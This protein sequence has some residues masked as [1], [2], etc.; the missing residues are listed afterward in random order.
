MFDMIEAALKFYARPG[1]FKSPYN[2]SFPVHGGICGVK[3][4]LLKM[5]EPWG[6]ILEAFSCDICLG[7]HLMVPRVH[8]VY[9]AAILVEVCSI[10]DD[11]LNVS[12]IMDL[13]RV[14]GKPVIL[15]L[16]KLEF[17]VSGLLGHLSYA[18][19]LCDP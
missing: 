18:V 11:V 4:F 15:D 14:L 7:D 8:N 6:Y 13:R 19:I 12:V 2:R 3:A 9:K 10:I 17:A 5:Q 1:E 16:L